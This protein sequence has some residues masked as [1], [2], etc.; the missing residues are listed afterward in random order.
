MEFSGLI[1]GIE[2]AGAQLYAYLS[3]LFSELNFIIISKLRRF[4]D[5]NRTAV[6]SRGGYSSSV[7]S[8]SLRETNGRGGL[9]VDRGITTTTAV[10]I[11][12][13]IATLR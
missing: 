8:R 4:G 12:G 5:F 10:I 7:I 2:F 1:L 11:K 6:Y 3:T 13:Y 9:V